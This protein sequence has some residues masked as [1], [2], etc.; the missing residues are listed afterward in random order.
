LPAGLVAAAAGGALLY[1]RRCRAAGVPPFW[2][3]PRA[4][5]PARKQVVLLKRIPGPFVPP[6]F[7]KGIS[8][9]DAIA[10]L[11]AQPGAVWPPSAAAPA[12]A[13]PT[14]PPALDH[15]MAR[16]LAQR[17]GD[18]RA[19]VG[20]P[21]G[22]A[23][24]TEDWRLADLTG[25][26]RRAGSDV[27]SAGSARAASTAPP[28]GAASARG[29]VTSFLSS[30]AVATGASPAVGAPTAAAAQ[31]PEGDRSPMEALR[32]RFASMTGLLREGAVQAAKAR[33]DTPPPM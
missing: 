15:P 5:P 8:V 13:P 25:A 27:R 7:Y 2:A 6:V 33:A 30:V 20:P 11:A 9:P 21:P 3:A 4:P 1:R 28:T 19:P 16:L 31:L 23:A 18:G 29:A 10:E 12:T 17:D 22:G 14:P 32:G 24:E 26:L